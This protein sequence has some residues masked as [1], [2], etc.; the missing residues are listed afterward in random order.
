MQVPVNCMP[1]PHLVQTTDVRVTISTPCC[2]R[3]LE[4]VPLF[5]AGRK[6]GLSGADGSVE[7]AL[8]PGEHTLSSPGFCPKEELVV[9]EPGGSGSLELALAASGELFFYL[10]DNTYEEDYKDGL[11]LT[12]SRENI[13]DDAGRFV[14]AVTWRDAEEEVS[15]AAAGAQR[16][17][18]TC[19]PMGRPC[20]HSFQLLTIANSGDG[21]EYK[22]NEDLTWF[23][24]FADECEVSLLFTNLPIRIGDL[25]GQRPSAVAAGQSPAAAAEAPSPVS[26]P[27]TPQ[28]AQVI[29][30]RR[31]PPKPQQAAAE[32][33][34]P[35]RTFSPGLRGT[36]ARA[37]STGR[38]LR[39]FPPCRRSDSPLI[40]GRWCETTPCAEP[41]LAFAP[42]R[43][44]S[45]AGR[46]SQ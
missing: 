34:P 29:I 37:S 10:Q 4:G 36:R 30:R 38:P 45:L 14:G 31:P 8:P 11:M 12:C 39:Q 9:I 21:R 33:L 22:K 26:R 6:V 3:G 24:D 41:R 42:S 1:T 40:V 20:S 44:R 19:V 16:P 23:D 43:R 28:D 13:P 35:S 25:I 17:A 27:S 18:R 5:V 2:G 15:S 7:V 46:R 32:R